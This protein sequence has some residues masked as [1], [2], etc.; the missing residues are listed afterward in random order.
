MERWGETRYT[1]IDHML[2]PFV[3]DTMSQ[4]IVAAILWK[5]GDDTIFIFDPVNQRQELYGRLR[6]ESGV[7]GSFSYLDVIVQQPAGLDLKT[8]PEH[9]VFQTAIDLEFVSEDNELARE[10][11][12]TTVR[13][14]GEPVRLLSF[15]LMN[16][17]SERYRKWDDQEFPITVSGVTD[18]SGR[19]LE[20][21]HKYD[22]LLVLLPEPLQPGS[23]ASIT[24][25]AEGGF[26]KNFSG[27]AYLVLGN[28]AY[29]PQL[30][31]YDTAASFHSVVK[32][33]EPFLPMACGR[34]VRRWTED[35]MN[36]VESLEEK[37]IA[38]P[39]RHR[40]KI[41]W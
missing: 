10:V 24:V 25:V 32:V 26:L 9:R 29:L 36:C 1:G 22:E 23:S 15:S 28:M 18:Q 14:G 3:L 20:F 40:R 5:G 30:D 13:A 31:I 21:S 12:T 35:G 39:V 27:D 37:P 11:T 19:A 33:K 2:A 4:P 6:K 16:G 34:T 17:R 8:R 38:F 41:S 7:G